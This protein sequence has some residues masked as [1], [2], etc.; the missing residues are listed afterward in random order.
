MKKQERSE[1]KKIPRRKKT[2][3]GILHSALSGITA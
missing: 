3:L 1:R 2:E